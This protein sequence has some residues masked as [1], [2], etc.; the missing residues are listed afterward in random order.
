MEEESTDRYNSANVIRGHEPHR[1]TLCIKKRTNSRKWKCL[2]KTKFGEKMYMIYSTRIYYSSWYLSAF[3]W[4]IGPE[5]GQHQL[6]NGNGIWRRQWQ[7]DWRQAD[8]QWS[9]KEPRSWCLSRNFIISFQ[10]DLKQINT[11]FLK[12]MYIKYNTLSILDTLVSPIPSYLNFDS[13]KIYIIFVSH[14]HNRHRA[15]HL[16]NI[17]NDPFIL[18]GRGHKMW[19]RWGGISKHNPFKAK[20]TQYHSSLSSPYRQ[21]FL[22]AN[23]LLTGE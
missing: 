14:E 3:R 11:C 4:Y 9:Q 23:S 22:N 18:H 16:L 13:F 17:A 10:M 21:N 19:M 6:E 7:D 2:I 20:V 8:R 12:N 5:R 15:S 1:R